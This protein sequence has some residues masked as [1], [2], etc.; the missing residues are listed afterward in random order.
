MDRREELLGRVREDAEAL[1]ALANGGTNIPLN[2]YIDRTSL[3]ALCDSLALE[4][5]AWQ[6]EDLERIL[7]IRD[8][9]Y[10]LR[11]KLR[12]TDEDAAHSVDRILA[13]GDRLYA[14]LERAF[15]E[16][17]R[18]EL[19][20]AQAHIAAL[21]RG[22]HISSSSVPQTLDAMSESA[23]EVITQAHS[24]LRHLD[25]NLLKIDRSNPDFE[26]LK[27]VKLSVQRLS[28]SVFAIKLSAEQKVIYQGVFKML[29]DSA[30][31]VVGELRQLVMKIQSSYEKAVSLVGDLSKLADQGT[32]FSRLVADF[33]NTA[34]LDLDR[35]VEIVVQLKLQTYHNGEPILSAAP[36]GN[37]VLLIGKN[38]NAW[39]TDPRSG[40]IKPRFRVHDRAVFAAKAFENEFGEEVLALGTDDG[41]IVSIDE[42][43]G[44][45]RYRSH[46]RERIISIVSPPWGAKGSRGTIVS[47]GRDGFVRRWT[48]AEDRLS[49][50]SDESYEQIGRRLQCMIVNG[51]EVIAAS[52]RELIFLDQNMRTLRTVQVPN[53]VTSMDVVNKDT[54]V[55]CGE[56]HISHVNLTGGAFSRMITASNDATYCCV[57][58]LDNDSFYFGTTTGRV[59]VMQL[60]SGIELGSTN[61]GFPLVG[62]VVF[63][64]KLV[65]YGG[66]WNKAGRQGRS[67]AILNIETKVQPVKAS[68]AGV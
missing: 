50:M 37:V 31:R 62:I 28:A 66:D 57:A 10:D 30:D 52:Q 35:N 9:L 6:L 45:E 5:E 68:A 32:R 14:D 24:S 16:L 40:T 26:V 25:L 42:D 51:G 65:A 44:D 33:L 55:V 49:Q 48:L 46:M 1:S 56:G 53:E 59:G 19:E 11:N 36:Q 58:A 18:D 23:G 47:G 61:V 2:D 7:I 63:G 60:S 54:L 27:S 20:A 67:A 43:A 21:H 13:A 8:G 39:V 22:P 38:G 64:N 34:F 12:D 4:A 29:S 15:R 3:D 17:K 41:L